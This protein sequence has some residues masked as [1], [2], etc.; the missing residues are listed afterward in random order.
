MMI[1][2]EKKY[3]VFYKSALSDILESIA[4]KRFSR[5]GQAPRSP[6]SNSIS[7]KNDYFAMHFLTY[8]GIYV[9]CKR[10]QALSWASN[11]VQVFTGMIMVPEFVV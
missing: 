6:F 5:S 7:I 11:Q 2:D 3:I 8:W 1:N 9:T 10:F 4:L